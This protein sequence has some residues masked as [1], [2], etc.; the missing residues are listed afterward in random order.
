[1]HCSSLQ[2]CAHFVWCGVEI[3]MWD[4][5]TL[6]WGKKRVSGHIKD[7][8][9]KFIIQKIGMLVKQKLHSVIA[10]NF[11]IIFDLLIR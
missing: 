5:A 7:N 10:F 1:M 4:R 2:A 8:R 11:N 9:F 3:A 6:E